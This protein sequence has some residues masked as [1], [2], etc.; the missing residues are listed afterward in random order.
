MKN[1]VSVLI[2]AL[3]LTVS[4]KAQI[5]FTYDN[6]DNQ[7]YTF[8]LRKGSEI[9]PVN[10]EPG[11]KRSVFIDTSESVVYIAGKCPEVPVKNGAHLEIVQ[12]CIRLKKKGK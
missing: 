12:G 9:I 4:V 10:F 1:L 11:L 7:H 6:R 8:K 2:A 5:S 3:V